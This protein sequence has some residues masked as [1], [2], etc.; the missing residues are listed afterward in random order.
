MLKQPKLLSFDEFYNAHY[1]QS[2]G[3]NSGVSSWE[4]VLG[5]NWTFKTDEEC[6][7]AYQEWYSKKYTKL[8]KLLGD[9]NEDRG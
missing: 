4:D 6:Y 7:Q 2:L 8:G 3:A 9:T 1:I 5:K